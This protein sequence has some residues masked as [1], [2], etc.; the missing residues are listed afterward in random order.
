VVLMVV[1]DRQASMNSTARTRRMADSW[2][3][4]SVRIPAMS[5]SMAASGCRVR[6]SVRRIPTHRRHSVAV[7]RCRK[8][9]VGVTNYASIGQHNRS[10]SV[11]TAMSRPGQ[12]PHPRDTVIRASSP[13]SSSAPASA[14]TAPALR[15]WPRR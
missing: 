14:W 9:D 7:N 4:A 8:A 1:G 12:A 5:I 15:R 13:R 10:A 2:A 11:I 3:P 6:T